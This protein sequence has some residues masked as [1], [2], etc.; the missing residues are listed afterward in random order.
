MS[1]PG[2]CNPGCDGIAGGGGSIGVSALQVRRSGEA[3]DV[4][5]PRRAM[6]KHAGLARARTP[7]ATTR[8][9]RASP[10]RQ[11]GAAA[12][13]LAGGLGSAVPQP[14]LCRPARRLTGRAKTRSRPAGPRRHR[15]SA[16]PPDPRHH[17][18]PRAW[19]ADIAAGRRRPGQEVTARPHD[20]RRRAPAVRGKARI[21][22]GPNPFLSVSSPAPSASSDEGCRAAKPAWKLGRAGGPGHGTP[23]PPPSPASNSQLGGTPPLGHS[24][25]SSYLERLA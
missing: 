10:P 13:R 8:A 18:P 22:L 20:H 2:C 16:D 4:G 21:P 14:G 5:S 3:G 17:H 24:A 1:A 12:G 7:A 6:V 15:C 11:A 23:S 25:T 9:R 19:D